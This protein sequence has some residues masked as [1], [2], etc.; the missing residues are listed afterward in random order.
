MDNNLTYLI[1]VVIFAIIIIL[2]F[3]FFRQRAQVKIKEPLGTGLD[4]NASNEPNTP[5]PAIKGQ[6]LTSRKGGLAA[7]D[8]TGRGVDI[9]RA[10]VEKDINLS[11]SN[12]P[13][14]PPPA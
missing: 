11:S 1:I 5:N 14:A 2:A 9:Q 6:D 12:D 4:I 13:K 10:E 8:K 3:L 7:H